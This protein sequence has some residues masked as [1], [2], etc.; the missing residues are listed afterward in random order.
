[1]A[2]RSSGSPPA[3]NRQ[4]YRP[5]ARYNEDQVSAQDVPGNHSRPSQ[6]VVVFSIPWIVRGAETGQDAINIAVS[7]VGKRVS[8]ASE[9]ARNVDISVQELGCNQ[10]ETG[11]DALLLVSETALVGLLL[12]VE[13]DAPDSKTAETVARRAIGSQLHDTPL[14]SVNIFPAA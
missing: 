13:V 2:E 1:M 12:E 6:Y 9:C 3:T 4:S 11:T 5:N 10:C 7:E 14:T 8:S